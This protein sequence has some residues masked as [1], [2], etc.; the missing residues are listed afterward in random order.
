VGPR[1]GD[2]PCPHRR[3]RAVGGRTRAAGL[4]SMDAPCEWEEAEKR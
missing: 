2:A 1:R 4:T 3:G